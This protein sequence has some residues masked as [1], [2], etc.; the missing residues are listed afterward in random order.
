VLQTE[1]RMLKILV[2]LDGS[3][4]ATTVLD[5]ASRLARAFGAKLFLFRAVGLPTEVPA[6]ALHMKP[7]DFVRLLEKKARGDLE[8]LSA[9]VPREAL[10]GL[11]VGVATP[12]GGI[13]EAA[14]KYAVDLIVLGAHGY[15]A[16]DRLL[17]TTAAKVVNRADR[18]VLVVREYN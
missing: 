15:G 10:G 17:G 13:L 8:V 6:E 7:D 14:K 16:V 9:R 3:A 1:R 12:A 4:R 2:A 18:S 11:E 5:E